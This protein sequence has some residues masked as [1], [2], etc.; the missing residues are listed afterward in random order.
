MSLREKHNAHN[1]LVFMLM[2]INIRKFSTIHNESVLFPWKLRKD[3]CVFLT[4]NATVSI[5]LRL[6]ISQFFLK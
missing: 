1:E 5:H 2:M 3:G 6:V 4:T